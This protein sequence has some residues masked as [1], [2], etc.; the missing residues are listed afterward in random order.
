MS[1]WDSSAVLPLCAG[2]KHSPVAEAVRERGADIVAWWA[3][4]VECLSGIGRMVRHGDLTPTMELTAI[5]RLTDLYEEWLEIAPTEAVRERAE[6]LVRRHALK[7]ADAFQL[8][9]ALDW[10]D[11]QARGHS[12]VTFDKRLAAAARS[13][14]FRVVGRGE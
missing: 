7:A 1:F 13:E 2:E 9:A 4:R 6:R 3:T 10:A 11:D 5:E 8:A 14:G 12:F